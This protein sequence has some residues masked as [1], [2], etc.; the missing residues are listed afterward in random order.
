MNP[1]RNA[2]PGG[3]INKLSNLSE[4]LSC[5]NSH[6]FNQ[7]ENSAKREFRKRETKNKNKRF[8]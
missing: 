2:N 8:A 7:A 1:Q 6:E 3:Q 4:I 5:C